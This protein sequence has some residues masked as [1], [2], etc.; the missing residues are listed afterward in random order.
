MRTIKFKGHDQSQALFAATLR[1]R[2]ADYFQERN[3]PTHG[4]WEIQL[5]S[6]VM[7]SLYFI[8]FI[9]LLT[10]P[11]NGWLALL[12][13]IVMGFGVAGIGMGIM[14]DANHGSYS[15]KRWLN[16]VMG[17]SIY[18]LGANV[19]NWK[20]QHNVLHHTYTNIEGMDGDINSLGPIRLSEHAPV[21]K[22]HRYQYIY[23]FFL[24]GLMTLMKLTKDFWQLHDFNQRGIT[25]A[26]QRSP[27]FEMGKMIVLKI[28]YFALFLGLPLWLSSFAAWEVF[29]GFFIMHWV[30]GCILATVFQLAHVV[31]GATQ[32]L[33]KTTG[34]IENDWMVHELETT[35]NFAP[36]NRPLGWFIGG[37][38]Y[39]IEH[40]LFPNI[41]HVHYRKI[42][43]IVEQTANDFGHAYNLKP[44]FGSALA[45]HVRRLKA[46][47]R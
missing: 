6:A 43:Y 1:K 30:A 19:F 9:L 26:Q 47:G 33:E 22:I 42:A 24:Y 12:S 40:H 21:K 13:A 45:S 38:N 2:V 8:P 35:S 16:E 11:M 20:M 17:A 27:R 10:V 37:L 29:L 14:H 25:Q 44:T 34:H 18:L 36:K 4:N 15:R 28:V 32:P 46:L 5:K 31:E 41:S 7:L 3:L 39:Q 23:A